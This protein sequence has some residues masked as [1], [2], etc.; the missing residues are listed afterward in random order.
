MWYARSA[1]FMQ[2]PHM[3]V[4]RWMRAFGDTL[5][6]VGIVAVAVFVLRQRVGRD[7]G[8][9]ERGPGAEPRRVPDRAGKAREA[10]LVN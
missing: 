8:R 2:Q 4:L 7:G 9:V 1:E 6:A 5:F 3:Q 10:A